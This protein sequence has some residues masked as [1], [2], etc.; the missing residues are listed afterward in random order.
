MNNLAL[1][2]LIGLGFFV[3]VGGI[4]GIH[5]HYLKRILKP[6]LSIIEGEISISIFSIGVILTGKWQSKR[7]EIKATSHK[8]DCGILIK[9]YHHFPFSCQIFP[10]KN[11]R[12]VI[13]IPP[14]GFLGSK[15]KIS[16]DKLDISKFPYKN[17]FTQE[18]REAIHFIFEKGFDY[19]DISNNYIATRMSSGTMVPLRGREKE[20]LRIESMNKILEAINLFLD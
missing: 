10:D 7:V 5:V 9:F 14:Y 4:V 2:I 1:V 3:V 13:S 20:I 11:N 12:F 8:S 19:I 15:N 16:E 6:F 18:R 17:F